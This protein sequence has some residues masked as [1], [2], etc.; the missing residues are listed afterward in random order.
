MKVIYRVL[1]TRFLIPIFTFSLG[2]FLT[3]ALTNLSCATDTKY[4]VAAKTDS[5][6]VI[7][8]LSAPGN[9]VRRNA[10]RDT[11]LTIRPHHNNSYSQHIYIPTYDKSGFLRQESIEDQANSLEIN[12][13]WLKTRQH[14]DQPVNTVK[15]VHKFAIAT[16]GLTSTRRQEILSE[17]NTYDDLLLLDGLQDSYKNLTTKLVRSLKS[18]TESYSFRY[19]LKCDDD[20]YVKLDMLLTYLLGYDN[21]IT[22]VD[23]GPNPAPE[24]YWGYFNG[25]ANVKTHG[26]WKESNFN[27]CSKY[28]PYALGGGYVITQKLVQYVHNNADILNLY[29]SEDISVG[30]WFASMRNVFRKHDCRFDTGYM[31]RR[32]KDYYIVLHKRSAEDM[33]TMFTGTSECNV[34]ELSEDNAKRPLEYFY[35]WKAAPMQCCDTLINWLVEMDVRI[36]SP[37]SLISFWH[38]RTAFES[39]VP[40]KNNVG[41]SELSPFLS[42]ELI[43]N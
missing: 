8:I 41:M 28:L 9:I 30:I 19:L 4:D 13:L 1:S 21:K 3:N 39:V 38:F 33:R 27:L 35:N 43:R 26:Q 15:V 25:K 31:A 40:H 12:K 10:I 6:L 14:T 17:A 34:A 29:L 23:F 32:C 11:W 16:A 42:V 18:V 7:L 2:C 20:T 36:F 5:F 24:L 37:I 22:S